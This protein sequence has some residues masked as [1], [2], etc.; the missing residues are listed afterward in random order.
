[1]AAV[2]LIVK[3]RQLVTHLKKDPIMPWQ[4]NGAFLSPLLLVLVGSCVG[5]M[6]LF[7]LMVAI[8]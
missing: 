7:M 5:D 6:L 4:F 1:M 2:L 8:A 3:R